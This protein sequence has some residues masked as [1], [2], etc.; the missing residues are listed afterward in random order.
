MGLEA[1]KNESQLKSGSDSGDLI[2]SRRDGFQTLYISVDIGVSMVDVSWYMF[3]AELV[4]IPLKALG[5]D[6]Q[7]T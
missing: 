5:F 6:C 4:G 3:P 2:R 1:G 7:C